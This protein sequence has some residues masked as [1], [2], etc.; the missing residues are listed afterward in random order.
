MDLSKEIEN[1]QNYLISK[2]FNEA[3]K[4]CEELL[5]I[6]PQNTHLNNLTG[7]TLQ[8]VGRFDVSANFFLKAIKIDPNNIRAKNNLANTYNFLGNFK[9]AEDLYIQ[10]LKIDP[11]NFTCLTNYARLKQHL[12]DFEVAIPLYEKATELDPK[13]IPTLMNLAIAQTSIGN[14]NQ[15]I[16]LV[17]KVITLKPDL[18]SAHKFKSSIT[19]YKKNHEHLNQ[20]VDLSKLQNLDNEKKIDLFFALG[21]AFEDIENYE[22]AFSYYDEANKIMSKKINYNIS[23]EE[24]LFS[25]IYETFKDI[26]LNKTNQRLS[27]KKIIF[28]CGMPRSGTTLVEQI[29]SSHKDVLGAGELYYLQQSIN[30]N[31]I[32]DNKLVKEWIINSFNKNK[33]QIYNDYCNLLKVHNLNSEIITDKAPQ[34][35]RWI[36][37]IRLFFPNSKI[38]HCTRNPR[39]TCLSLFKNSF[40]SLEMNWVYS[41]ENIAT[42]YNLYS[43][44]MRFWKSKIP[45]NIHDIN[46]EKLTQNKDLEIKNLLKFCNLDYDKSCLQHHKNSKTPIKSAS[47]SQARKPINSSSI[48]KSEIYKKNL[49]QMFS[50]LH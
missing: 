12:T 3:L 5:K 8:Q 9:K 1:I 38:I 11:N 18:M 21:K 4:S 34:N 27:E 35:F 20:M 25:N 37:F 50:L 45:N 30:K 49:N 15:S 24:T 40:G 14:I 29:L 42:Y 10:I 13:N 22:K 26:D 32:K 33:N 16:N 7:I 47:A 41:Q 6:F 28:I 17:D 2:K 23:K 43:K 31:F 46:Y 48:N 39:D 19:Q 36:G 44:L